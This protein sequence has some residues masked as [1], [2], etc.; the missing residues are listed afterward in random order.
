MNV[1]DI[2][3]SIPFPKGI[4]G[5]KRALLMKKIILPIGLLFIIQSLLIS[6]CQL[7]PREPLY[8]TVVVLCGLAT[9]VLGTLLW[10]RRDR[11]APY[12]AAQLL[13]VVIGAFALLGMF[14]IDKSGYLAEFE[15]RMAGSPR[16]FYSALLIVPVMMVFFHI[17]ESGA[18]RK[19]G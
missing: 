3:A 9:N 13:L 2:L 7:L 4:M 5:E 16:K 10:G 19:G 8:G 12:V 17:L 11:I 18:K 1:N 6:G 15:P 14:A